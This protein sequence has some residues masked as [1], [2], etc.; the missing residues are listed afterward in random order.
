M[1]IKVKTIFCTDISQIIS[2]RAEYFMEEIVITLFLV[3]IVFQ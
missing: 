1:K 2:S 3:Y